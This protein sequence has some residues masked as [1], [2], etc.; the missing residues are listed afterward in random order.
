M[1]QLTRL[2]APARVSVILNPVVWSA[3]SICPTVASGFL[4][5]RIAQ[6]PATWGAATDVP[7]AIVVTPVTVVVEV[8]IFTPGATRDKKDA[9]FEEVQIFS[10]LGEEIRFVL[11]PTLTADERQPGKL[12]SLVFESFPDAMTVAIPDDRK[13][14]ICDFM[15][16]F[17]ARFGSA[18]QRR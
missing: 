18:S 15:R 2:L 4:C 6:A 8:A 1:R 17:V 13:A 10:S 11:A 5:F 7:L 9:E 12:S 16:A 3:L 14:S